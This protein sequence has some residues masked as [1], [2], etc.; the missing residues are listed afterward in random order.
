MREPGWITKS[1]AAKILDCDPRT[2]ERKA[3]AGKIASQAR[4]GFPTWYW[5][6][7]VEKLQQTGTGEVRTGV[8]ESVMG[9][10]NGMQTHVS[11]S[12]HMP[13][14]LQA[15]FVEVLQ[16]LRAALTQG[17]IGP[18]GPTDGSTGPTPAYV[19]KADALA[20]V[21]ISDRE[22]RRAVQAGEVKMRGRRYRR[23]DLEAL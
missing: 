6:A 5:Q 4:P 11:T 9:N 18:T 15:V 21:G 22:L 17:P 23:T 1:E 20:L 16:A 8:L 14:S 2:I 12:P 19:G 13:P 3:A 7:D 10:G